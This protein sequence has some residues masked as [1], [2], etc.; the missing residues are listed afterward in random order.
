MLLGSFLSSLLPLYV[1]IHND[2][3]YL[4]MF[5]A[6]LYVGSLVLRVLVTMARSIDIGKLKSLRLNILLR[7][8]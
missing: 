6:D 5:A 7:T 8:P 4:V 2:T 1:S 3:R